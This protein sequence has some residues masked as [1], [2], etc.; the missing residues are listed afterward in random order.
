ME[1]FNKIFLAL[2]SQ[3]IVGM[4]LIMVYH[5]AVKTHHNDVI[6]VDMHKI[7]GSQ[8]SEIAQSGL[9]EEAQKEELKKVSNK[10]K[11]AI[12]ELNARTKRPIVLKDVVLAGAIDETDWIMEEMEIK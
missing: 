2:L 3:C 1:K 11:N 9:S 7:M 8:L 12:S 4:I 6:V 10:I 5:N